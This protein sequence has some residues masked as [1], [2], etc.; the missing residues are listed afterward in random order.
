MAW[1]DVSSGD[2]DVC[3]AMVRPG[4][5][6]VPNREFK[7]LVKKGFNPAKAGRLGGVAQL[8]LT[9]MYGGD[10]RAWYDNWS[11]S[12]VNPTTTDWVLCEACV[13]AAGGAPAHV[14]TKERAS[15]TQASRA[16]TFLK[17]AEDLVDERHGWKASEATEPDAVVKP[18]ERRRRRW[19]VGRRRGED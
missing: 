2:C 3:G 8:Q 17:S 6:K 19:R 15:A 11:A 5:K 4:G 12:I 16:T 7:D 18:E 14:G 1:Q 10:V 9:M 13:T